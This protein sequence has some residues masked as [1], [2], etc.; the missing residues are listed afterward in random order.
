MDGMI[1]NVSLRKKPNAMEPF[2]F[3]QIRE[4]YSFQV[5][6]DPALPSLGS[7]Q[8]F[9]THYKMMSLVLLYMSL[10]HNYM[11]WPPTYLQRNPMPRGRQELLS[12]QGKEERKSHSLQT[13]LP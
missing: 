3:V 6:I 8:F 4:G 9:W 5:I 1:K 2:I 11:Q 13:Q 12:L 7:R 10:L